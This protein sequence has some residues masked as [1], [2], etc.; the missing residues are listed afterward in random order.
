MCGIVVGL[1]FG[2]LNQRDESMRQK[3]LR[4]F[5]TELMIATEERGKD[6]TGAAI[7]FN[8]GKYMG[9]KRGEKVTNFL[10]TFA[11]TK[12][13]YASLLKVWKEHGQRVKVYL[14]HCRAGTGG[15]KEDNEN[16]HPIKIGNLIGIHNGQI[17]NHNIIF[18]KLGCSRDAKVDSEAIFRL[19]DYYTKHGKEPFTM[20]MIQSIVDRLDGQFAVTLFNAD[21]L[22]QVP[23]FRDGRPVE[24]V[25]L[26]RYGIL[27]IMSELKFWDRVHFRY[28][29]MVNYNSDI[30]NAKMPSFL[31]K[32]DIV[33]KKMEDD[34]AYIF[35]LSKKVTDDTMIRD[36]CESK[37][38]GRNEK[39]WKTKVVSYNSGYKTPIQDAWN[40]ADDAKKRRVF[41]KITKMYMVKV[42]DKVLDGN[43]ST[44]LPVDK[45][46]VKPLEEKK[47]KP[48]T[49]ALVVA[50]NKKDGFK[51]DGEEET[52]SGTKV[53]LK[54]HTTYDSVEGAAEAAKKN[55]QDDHDEAPNIGEVID[56][57]PKDITVINND[58]TLTEVQMA[59]YPPEIIEAANEAYED[60]PREQKGCGNLEEL[61]D[62]IDIETKE[63]ADI[64]GMPLVGNRA[65]KHGW[66]QGY[67][68][69]LV[70]LSIPDE[71]TKKREHHIASL[72]SLVMLMTRF[73]YKS[74]VGS[75]SRANEGFNVMVKKRL[76]QVTLDG[77]RSIDIAEL[78]K[79][80][81]QHDRQSLKEVS[82]IIS[83][84]SDV[85]END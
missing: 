12:E 74:K 22:D 44:T 30:Y 26:R 81:N 3:L 32:G 78:T 27:L 34:M 5:T 83:Q 85:I 60:L 17:K 6:A 84:A 43:K 21:N 23:I 71:R 19:F 36:I 73:Y 16:N 56:V 39:I 24:L 82:D 72:K 55:K 64:L 61:L 51:K 53:E 20:E 8:D 9:I 67:M 33:T 14:G 15:D 48:G 58:T 28:E 62:I 49:K 50:D 42:G 77:G 37:K 54:D 47:D 29:R 75:A 76:A 63:K 66:L 11:E 68:N 31:D 38:M 35:D 13:H 7:L 25:L 65:I 10:S 46:E 80:F 69:A 40:K 45:P 41:D 4:Y 57:D 59:I 52:K 1:A 70:T 2:K 79:I 18:D